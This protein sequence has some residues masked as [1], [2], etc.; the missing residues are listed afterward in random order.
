MT[1]VRK[2]EGKP[3]STRLPKGAVDTQT[4]MYL[5]GYPPAKGASHVPEGTP[6]PADYRRVMSWLGVERVVVTQGN[7]HGFD[8]SNLLA[9]LAAMGGIARGVAVITGETSD[10]EMLRLTEAGIVGA[11]I[12]DLPGGAVGLAEIEAVD[13]RAAEFGWCLAVQFDGSNLLEC[14]QRLARLKSRWIFDH[15]GKFFKGVTPDDPE[16]AA[17]KRLLD[18][19]RC[20][21]KFAACYESSRTGAPLYEDI[22]AVARVVAA[23]APERIL[24]GTN[25]PHNNM[26]TTED[27]PDDAA[28][29][30][31]VMSWFPDDRGRELALVRNPEELFFS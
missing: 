2:L 25:W 20:W 29:L 3:P 23:H 6:S 22:A 16:I 17:V 1:I 15:H 28:L 12:M 18:S 5:P 14:E 10:A 24:W 31:R 26:K 27:Y 21:F 11:R 30:D 7:A 9:C 13:A 4:H 8:N 19:G